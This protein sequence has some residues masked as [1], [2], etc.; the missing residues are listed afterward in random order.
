MDLFDLVV[1]RKMSGGGGGGGGSS[2]FSTANVTID[3]GEYT[4]AAHVLIASSTPNPFTF[5]YSDNWIQADGFYNLTDGKIQMLCGN[6][7]YLDTSMF[8]LMDS[9]QESLAYCDGITS[10]SDNYT[11]DAETQRILINGDGTIVPIWVAD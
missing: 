7:T 4:A 2:D 3:V 9:E 1:A 10:V 5:V 11:Y 6:G 8:V